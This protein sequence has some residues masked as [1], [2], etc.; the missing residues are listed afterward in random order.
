[1]V[2]VAGRSRTRDL[3]IEGT[4]PKLTG[5]MHVSG[6]I[7]GLL[8]MASITQSGMQKIRCLTYAS[9]YSLSKLMAGIL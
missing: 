4:R 2:C 9:G 5:E 6:I 8:W 7:S 1:M 3:V